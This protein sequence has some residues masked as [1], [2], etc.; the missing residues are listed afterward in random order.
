VKFL[1]IT[2]VQ[3]KAHQR[4]FWAY[5]PYIREM[6]LWEKHIDTLIV[7]APKI[8]TAP[9]AIDLPYVSKQLV[10]IEVPQVS[11][12]GMANQLKAIF[13]IP[14]IIWRLFKAMRKADHIHLR[15]PGN[16]GLMGAVVQILFPG[17]KKTAKYAGN[18]DWSSKQPWSYRLQQVILRNTLLTKNMK[19]LVY[20]EWPDRNE[21][22]LPFFTASYSQ[23]DQLGI[24]PKNM[25]DEIIRCMFVGTLTENKQPLLALEVFNQLLASGRLMEL[26]F[27]GEGALKKSLE[28]RVKELDLQDRV[29]IHGN[30]GAAVL[31]E[32]YKQSH[33]LL[34]FSK[35]E[36][37]PKAVSEAMWWGCVP[38]T[39]PVSCVAWML[40]NGRNGILVQHPSQ[41]FET[42]LNTMENNTVYRYMQ[43]QATKWARVYTLESFEQA[44]KQL[45]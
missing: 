33:F 37:W 34:F 16:M 14:L 30:V 41:A 13:F 32:A 28:A 15:C 11:F 38:V 22:I 29:T 6:N 19:T 8:D 10:F 5:G 9:S 18:W 39:T 7:V 42:I 25:D 20:G 12:V 27:Y 24:P 35:S 26:H 40:D 45:L 17:K 21:N 44:I 1:I 31:K 36:G 3:H 43:Q 23:A 2:H 4:Q